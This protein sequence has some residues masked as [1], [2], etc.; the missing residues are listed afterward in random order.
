MVDKNYCMSSYLAFRYIEA[1]DKDFFPGLHHQNITGLPDDQK[2][3]VVT[4]D[5]ID[6]VIAGQ[7]SLL[8]GE[9]LGILLSGGMDSAILAAYM[10][11]RDAYTFRFLD[12]TYQKEELQRAEYYAD[13]Y[14]LNLHYVD[15]SW[16][17]TVEPHLDVLMRA[18][19]APVH[20]I[21]PQILQAALQAK[22]DGVTR[23]VIG[24]SS[25]LIFGGMDQLLSQ[26]WAFSDFMKRYVFTQ[27]SDVL[28]QPENMQY[29]FE[30]YR[31]GEKIDFCRFMDDVFSIE[32]SSSYLNAFQVAGLPYTDPYACMKMAEPLDLKRV[33]SGESKYLIRELFAK[34]YPE[35]P[36]PEKVPMPR[37]VDSYFQ[38]W[39]GPVRHEFKGGLN[40]SSFSGNQKWQLYCLERFL[41]LY[42][43]ETAGKR[44]DPYA[45]V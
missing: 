17:N 16:E 24:E 29:L 23:M 8:E 42:E 43:P 25:D 21:E 20:S 19:A 1:D 22:G 6:Q 44:G 2:R 18:K 30:R 31:A 27:P 3:P 12:G 14:G 39:N 33:R 35:M 4:S 34:K 40:M 5:D 41:D 10:S 11:G 45:A 13:Y 38:K 37:P 28:V 36:V 32:S 26:D 7:F 15:I 9:K